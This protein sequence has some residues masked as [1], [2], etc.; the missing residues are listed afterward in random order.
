[1]CLLV[2]WPSYGR[3]DEDRDRTM[4]AVA[5]VVWHGLRDSFPMA[6]TVWWALII[7][8]AISAI[9]Q[10]WVPQIGRAHV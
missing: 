10:A 4:T 6:W 1:M 3:K 7:G 9:V 5:E 8:F 2:E